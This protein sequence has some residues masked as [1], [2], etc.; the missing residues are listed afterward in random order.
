MALSITLIGG[1]VFAAADAVAQ[2]VALNTFPPEQILQGAKLYAA[3]CAVCHGDK[4]IDQ[5]GGF[6]DLRTFPPQQRPRFISSV[7]NGKNSMPPWKSVLSQP[8]IAA[9]FAYVVAGE[10][11]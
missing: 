4:M 1:S 10:Q 11:K 5:G 6:F 8:E 9:L 2:D 3:N 7:S